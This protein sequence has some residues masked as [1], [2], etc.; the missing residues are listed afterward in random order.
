MYKTTK[1]NSKWIKNFSKSPYIL[2][3]L[4]KKYKHMLQHLGIGNALSEED[5][6]KDEQ[7]S[8]GFCI[9]KETVSQVK[10]WRMD[11]NLYQVYMCQM[12]DYTK[13]S[14]KLNSKKR[15]KKQPNLKI[16]EGNNIFKRRNTNG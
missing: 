16:A 3:L 5:L 10:K 13:H 11:K 12:I 15:K 4:E 14:R 1:L 2:K 7:Q 6:R 8:M 9:A